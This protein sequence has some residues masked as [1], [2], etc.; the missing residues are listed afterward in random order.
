MKKE[1]KINLLFIVCQLAEGLFWDN[2]KILNSKYRNKF[3]SA[4]MHV[5]HLNKDIEKLVPERVDDIEDDVEQLYNLVG[6][7]MKA[8]DQG[9]HDEFMAHCNHFF[10]E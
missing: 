4:L 2:H 6:L 5:K 3:N 7:S 8:T 10:N 9:A 1:N